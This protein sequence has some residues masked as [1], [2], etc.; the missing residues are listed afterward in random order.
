MPVCIYRRGGDNEVA[1]WR[2]SRHIHMR[3][4]HE[5]DTYEDAMYSCIVAAVSLTE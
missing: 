1:L 4:A 3:M 2:Q 5:A